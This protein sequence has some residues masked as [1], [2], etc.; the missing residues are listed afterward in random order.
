[1]TTEAASVQHRLVPIALDDLV[2]H[3]TVEP[4]FGSSPRL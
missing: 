3:E 4:G 2:L 1:M